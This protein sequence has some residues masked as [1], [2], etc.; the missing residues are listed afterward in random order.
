MLSRT[1]PARL[2]LDGILA[3]ALRIEVSVPSAALARRRDGVRPTDTSGR[4]LLI[5]E[6]LADGW[7]CLPTA[8][9]GLAKTIWCELP[10][11]DLSLA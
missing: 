10:D 8:E 9:P 3:G 2:I 7:G 1:P 4:G 6:A 5:V 11:R